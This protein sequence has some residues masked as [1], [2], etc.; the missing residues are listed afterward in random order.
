MNMLFG[1]IN[2]THSSFTSRNVGC[3][4]SCETALGG[5]A[6]SV[7][8]RSGARGG[9]DVRAR[10]TE[11]RGCQEEERHGEE[12]LLPKQRSLDRR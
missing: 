9:G 1:V 4:T 11:E 2:V 3:A 10:L 8:V 7:M 5:R 12:D 6:V